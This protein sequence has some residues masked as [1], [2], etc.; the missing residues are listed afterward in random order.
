MPLDPFQGELHMRGNVAKI[1]RKQLIED[2]VQDCNRVIALR[3]RPFGDRCKCKGSRWLSAEI[4]YG[5][6][7]AWPQCT[8]ELEPS[9]PL[10]ADRKLRSFAFAR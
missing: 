3:T 6:L 9:K 8:S 10:L 4:H 2:C 1:N 5:K 7:S